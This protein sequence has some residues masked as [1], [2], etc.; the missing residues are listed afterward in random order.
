MHAQSLTKNIGSGRAPLSIILL[1]TILVDTGCDSVLTT[2]QLSLVREDGILGEWQGVDT[3]GS[4]PADIG[5]IQYMDGEY[6]SG[7][8]EDFAKGKASHFTLARVGNV[9]I[10]QSPGK[11]DECGI[12]KSQ[13]CWI[14]S[15]IELTRDRMDWYDFDAR[16]LAKESLNG[17]LNVAHS[18]H[19][20]QKKD[21]SSDTKI[22]LSADSSELGHFLNSYVKR[23]AAFRLTTRFR[24]I[25]TRQ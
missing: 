11:C 6:W 2:V 9:L 12:Q 25:P 1:L 20:Q 18:V 19:R 24:R 7:S 17:A 10:A 8:P 21:G 14:L 15:R 22:L 5:L 13:V 23:R 3:P 16:T 4:T